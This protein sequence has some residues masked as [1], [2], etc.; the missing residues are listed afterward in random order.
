[1]SLKTYWRYYRDYIRADE[2]SEAEMV[3]EKMFD[4]MG[5]G[6]DFM[7]IASHFARDYGR[8][9][10]HMH[11]AVVLSGGEYSGEYM[12]NLSGREG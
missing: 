1:M 3:M 9:P 7:R 11:A 8:L 10:D 2:R 12:R 6:V 5:V 4:K